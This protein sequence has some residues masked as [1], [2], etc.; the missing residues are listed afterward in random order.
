MSRL[1]LSFFSLTLSG[2][3]VSH[4]PT[5]Q[6]AGFNGTG[7]YLGKCVEIDLPQVGSRGSERQDAF[8]RAELWRQLARFHTFQ[9]SYEPSSFLFSSSGRRRR[10]P[11]RCWVS[12]TQRNFCLIPLCF[13]EHAEWEEWCLHNFDPVAAQLRSVI[14]DLD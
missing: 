2:I 13:C 12:C 1:V 14:E 10:G 11:D 7:Q 3:I 4:C 9:P 5:A 8:S 6:Q